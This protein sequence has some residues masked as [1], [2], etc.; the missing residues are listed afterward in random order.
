MR[1]KSMTILG[2]NERLFPKASRGTP[3]YD[4]ERSKVFVVC[5]AK[6]TWRGFLCEPVPGINAANQ[7]VGG[8]NAGGR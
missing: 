1:I 8:W 5:T 4:V 7:I 3:L 6:S 2:I